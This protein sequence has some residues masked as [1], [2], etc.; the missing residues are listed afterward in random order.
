MLYRREGPPLCRVRLLEPLAPRRQG[1]ATGGWGGAGRA[2]GPMHA[3]T[4]FASRVPADPLVPPQRLC[5]APPLPA[6]PWSSLFPR[7]SRVLQGLGLRLGT[8][9]SFSCVCASQSFLL[10]QPLSSDGQ[11][12][13]PQGSVWAF[14]ARG[15]GEGG[16]L[17]RV[18][19]LP[20][21]R[22]H[23]FMGRLCQRSPPPRPGGSYLQD[24]LFY[25]H[26]IVK[27]NIRGR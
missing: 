7:C 5:Q 11:G 12:R 8:F 15:G 17:G 10:P 19:T 4:P 23:L 6:S 25:S 18:L 22:C 24:G 3:A 2:A 13:G 16:G 14:P 9:Q 20:D 27:R 1:R 21:A 26:L